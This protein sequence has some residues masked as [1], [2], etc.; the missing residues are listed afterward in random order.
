MARHFRAL[1]RQAMEPAKPYFEK[2]DELRKQG[3]KETSD[4]ISKARTAAAAEE[5]DLRA[6]ANLRR[7]LADALRGLDRVDPR[8]RK[9]LAAE[10]KAAL[11]LVDGRVSAQNTEVEAAKNALI[12]RATALGEVADTRTAI[13]QARDLQKLWQKAGNGKR[14]R[15]QAQWKTFRSAVDAVFARADNERAERSAQERKALESAAE[16]CTELESIASGH[17]PPDRATVQRIESAWRELATPDAALRQRFQSTQARLAEL[18]RHIEK[19]RHRA[20]FDIWMSHYKLCR[21]LESSEIDAEGFRAAESGLPALTLTI[22]ELRSRIE[23]AIQGT[24]RESGDHELLRDCVLE[25]E[26]LAGLEPPAEDRQRRMD[27]Q[28]E[29]LSARMRGVHAPAPDAALRN[30]LGD[31]LQLGPVSTEEAPLEIR[32][33][34]AFEAALDTLG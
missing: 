6:L 26:Q 5:P 7:Q 34:R 4:L 8:E 18:G 19:R 29:K 3:T 27:L 17:A 31:W 30:L 24:A 23:H 25:L 22:E 13:S 2:R 32:F 14:A 11:A 10:I 21:R 9:N 28:L 1:C 16:L 15:D 33:E 12:E 20:Q